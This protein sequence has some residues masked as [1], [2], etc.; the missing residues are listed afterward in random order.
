MSLIQNIQK[1]GDKLV[2]SFKGGGQK[3]VITPDQI[4][5]VMNPD[6]FTSIFETADAAASSKYMSLANGIKICWRT[7][8][9]GG[10]GISTWTFPQGG[11]LTTTGLVC[12]GAPQG[13]FDY[14]V[15]FATPTTTSV[16]FRLYG[17]GALATGECMLFAI[18]RWK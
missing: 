5:G 13:N 18:G 16:E 10:T 4:E 6:I 15:A 2:A 1:I 12:V 3:Q 8:S 11:F 9:S 14:H 17:D 7:Q